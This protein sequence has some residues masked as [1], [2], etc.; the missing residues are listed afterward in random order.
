MAAIVGAPGVFRSGREFAD[1]IG[2]VPQVTS[3]KVKLGLISKRGNGAIAIVQA[4]GRRQPTPAWRNA[5]A[6]SF[7]SRL[8]IGEAAAGFDDLAQAPA[9]RERFYSARQKN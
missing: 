1:S 3:G 8:V 2:L 6:T 9:H 7:Q 4:T 5:R